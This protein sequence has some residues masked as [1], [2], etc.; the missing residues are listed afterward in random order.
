[1]GTIRPCFPLIPLGPLSLPL[2]TS[3]EP[4]TLALAACLPFLRYLPSSRHLPSSHSLPPLRRLPPSPPTLAEDTHVPANS[5]GI[6]KQMAL[7]FY[8]SIEN[9]FMYSVQSSQG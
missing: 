5:G 9:V 7:Y 3:P 6:L 2:P 1:M 8:G 4:A